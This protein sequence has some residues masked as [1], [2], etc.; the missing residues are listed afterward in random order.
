[1]R[2]V[3]AP[4]R[5]T[6]CVP[7]PYSRPN[8]SIV[9]PRWW[10]IEERILPRCLL[11]KPISTVVLPRAGS[12]AIAELTRNGLLRPILTSANAP[13]LHAAEQESVA[14]RAPSLARVLTG[15][16]RQPD[17]RVDQL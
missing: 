12:V 14:N 17:P 11:P 3:L 9:I 15:R 1:M 10:R 2:S 6:T 4:V 5:V 13:T 7:L 16:Q 8:T